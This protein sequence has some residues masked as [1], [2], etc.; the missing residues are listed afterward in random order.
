MLFVLGLTI[1]GSLF[2]VGLLGAYEV[3]PIDVKIEDGKVIC[4][5]LRD[6]YKI[7]Y[8]D[9]K[10]ISLEEDFTKL[11]AVRTNG[12]GMPNLLKGNFKAKSIGKIKVFLNPENNYYI[13]VET[14]ERTYCISDRNDEETKEAYEK[15]CERVI[16]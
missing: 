11:K 15:I 5:Q 13:K 1:I 14:F 6:D 12:V 7:D 3:V 8:R 4:H 16:K 2:A 10:K 9:V